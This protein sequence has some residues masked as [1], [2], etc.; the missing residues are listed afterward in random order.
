MPTE[1]IFALIAAAGLTYYAIYRAKHKDIVHLQRGTMLASRAEHEE[2]LEAFK[3]ALE[4]NPDLIEAKQGMVESYRRLE[5]LDEAIASCRE[6]VSA[7]VND[8]ALVDALELLGWLCVEAGRQDEAA[9]AFERVVEIWPENV[10]VQMSL[11]EAEHSLGRYDDALKVYEQMASQHG[12]DLKLWYRMGDLY[13]LTGQYDQAIAAYNSAMEM[14]V[15]AGH[16]E[17]ACAQTVMILGDTHA[18]FGQ[19][20]QALAA[21]TKAHEPDP[22]WA[23]PYCGMGDVLVKLD[24]LDEAMASFNR[25]LEADDGWEDAWRG[26]GD[27]HAKAG[28][29]DEAQ[30]A[31]QKAIDLNPQFAAAHLDMGKLLVG[32]DDETGGKES[33]AQAAE[34]DPHGEVGNEARAALDEL[35]TPPVPPEE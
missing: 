33:L 32:T 4:A 14:H 19:Y 1:I 16:S 21:Y 25:A 28:R 24:K 18:Q 3:L 31:Y 23:A 6:V 17:A 12:P 30:A 35:A 9:E 5:K 20:D 29:A 10:D 26:I 8:R 34:L 22:T 11:A 7:A 27:A 13:R 15:T 2:A